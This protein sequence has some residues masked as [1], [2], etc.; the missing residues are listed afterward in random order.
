MFFRYEPYKEFSRMCG[1]SLF[2]LTVS[3]RKVIMALMSFG[4]ISDVFQPIVTSSWVF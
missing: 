2:L 3:L 4:F 1:V